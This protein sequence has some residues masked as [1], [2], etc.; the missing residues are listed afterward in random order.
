MRLDR[1]TVDQNLLRRTACRGQCMEDVSPDALCS[2][3]NE[4]VVKR[5]ARTINIRR[6][7]PAA[8]G[9]EH[10]HDAADDPSVVNPRLTPRIRRK[11]RLKPRKLTF[12]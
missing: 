9:F 1:R 3:S 7:N 4:P 10:V 8:T 12:R 6:V 5:F 2:P 11:K